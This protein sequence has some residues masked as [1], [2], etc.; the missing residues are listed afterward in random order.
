MKKLIVL[1]CII[2]NLCFGYK[3]DIKI[4]KLKEEKQLKIEKEITY[5]Q[6]NEWL[7]MSREE[8][9][10]LLVTLNKQSRGK[11]EKNIIIIKDI[12]AEEELAKIG[13]FGIEIK[14]GSG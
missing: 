1:F 14:V 2:F 7:L 6:R 9:I 13:I 8:K 11:E 4:N 5:I 10:Q 3:M 12:E